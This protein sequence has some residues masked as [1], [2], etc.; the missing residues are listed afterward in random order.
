MTIQNSFGA[1]IAKGWQALVEHMN[2]LNER[3]EATLDLPK[4]DLAGT[5]EIQ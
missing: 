1:R 5:E 4:D 3:D 2:R